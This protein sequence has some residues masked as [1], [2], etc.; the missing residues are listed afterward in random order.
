M[1]CGHDGNMSVRDGFTGQRLVVLPR[2]LI[3]AALGRPGTARL[4][5]TDC[6]YFPEARAHGRTREVPLAAAVVLVCVKGRGWCRIGG[7]SH[8]VRAGDVAVIPAGVTHAY[9]T[10]AQEPWTLWWLHVEGAD[11]AE[12]LAAAGMTKTAPVRQLDTVYRMV[13]L[14]QE[15]LDRLEKDLGDSSLLAS[16]GAAWHLLTLLSSGSTASSPQGAAVERATNYLR[17]HLGAAV[18][19]AELAEVAQLSQSHFAA[20]F[21]QQHGLPVHQFATQLRMAKARELLDTTTL[22]VARIAAAVGYP[23]AFY[24][25]RQFRAV[26]GTTALRYRAQQKG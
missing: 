20:L 21:K 17:A 25:S 1:I 7:T 22:P 9:G 15:I 12:I 16:S 10:D 5:V 8:E 18:S 2:P 14:V 13:A 4:L 23:D 19:V 26:H 3:R 24:F 6:G 11:V